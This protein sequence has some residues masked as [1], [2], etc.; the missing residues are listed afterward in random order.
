VIA[1]ETGWSEGR[2]LGMPLSRIE[3]Y[4]ETHNEIIEE[5]EKK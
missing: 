1:K 4:I 5:L 2:I 3:T